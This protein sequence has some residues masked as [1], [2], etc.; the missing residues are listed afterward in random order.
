[1]LR[2]HG[3]D[4]R[5]HDTFLL[6]D[7]TIVNAGV[8]HIVVAVITSA[9]LDRTE[10]EDE[11]SATHHSPERQ[12]L[13]VVIGRTRRRASPTASGSGPASSVIHCCASPPATPHSPTWWSG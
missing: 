13:P 4:V 3:A 9:Y 7:P 10:T 8:T 5:M 2:G 1:V 6:D 12:L 11:L